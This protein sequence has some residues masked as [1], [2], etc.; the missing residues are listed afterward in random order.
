MKKSST[1]KI[2]NLNMK[3]ISLLFN[4]VVLS[5]IILNSC[6][7]NTKDSTFA[8]ENEHIVINELNC[9]D[10]YSTELTM[11]QINLLSEKK[12]KEKDKLWKEWFSKIKEAKKK[13]QK[14][15]LN[16]TTFILC[17]RNENLYNSFLSK[18]KK[19]AK[20]LL[21]HKNSLPKFKETI[22]KICNNVI[23]YKYCY[24][25]RFGL[26]EKSFKESG[27][28]LLSNKKF[29]LNYS[30]L[31]KEVFSESSSNITDQELVSIN[32]LLK[33]IETIDQHIWCIPYYIQ[34][35][36]KI[37]V[38]NSKKEKNKKFEKLTQ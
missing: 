24:Y 5:F 22:I 37:N 2:I 26:Y 35:L 12:D 29:Y 6:T 13:G 18:R 34:A 23:E 10:S 19:L 20:K 14:L 4:S 3:K 27:G 9:W 7:Q 32:N 15:L 28:S 25:R 21:S 17:I 30:E 1:K 31:L 11:M 16:D 33:E 38:K 8:N 36:N